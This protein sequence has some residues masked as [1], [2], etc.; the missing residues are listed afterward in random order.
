MS[1]CSN[2]LSNVMKIVISLLLRNSI[3]ILLY[4]FFNGSGLIRIY[5]CMKFLRSSVNDF[6]YVSTC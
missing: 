2:L 4:N 6:V 5:A 3:P 1:D